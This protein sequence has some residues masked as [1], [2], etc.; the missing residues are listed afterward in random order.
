MSF[1]NLCLRP[2]HKDYNLCQEG[3]SNLSYS[4][5]RATTIIC[6]LSAFKRKNTFVQINPSFNDRIYSILKLWQKLWVRK[7]SKSPYSKL[8]I[9][10]SSS[11]TKWK[12]EIP[13]CDEQ[14]DY[15]GNLGSVPRTV[16]WAAQRIKTVQ[17]GSFAT[18]TS[19]SPCRWG[20]GHFRYF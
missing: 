12:L 20:A 19:P 11:K 8:S 18:R 4:L 1:T 9:V 5:K 6:F 16:R 17:G 2:C 15:H 7:K 10:K 13:C 3:F 14:Y